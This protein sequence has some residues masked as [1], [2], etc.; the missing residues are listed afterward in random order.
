MTSLSGAAQEVPV[1]EGEDAFRARMTCFIEKGNQYY[2]LSDRPGILSMIDSLDACLGAR[3]ESGCLNSADSLEYTAHRCRLLADWHYENGNYDSQSYPKAEALFKEALAIFSSG[4]FERDYDLFRR[5][6]LYRELA[7]LYYKQE[8]YEEALDYTD[9]AEN[10]YGGAY[11]NGYFF[12]GSPDWD[13]W[14]AVRMQ[15]A[16]CLARTGRFEEALHLADSVSTSVVGSDDGIRLSVLRMRGKILLLQGGEASRKEAAV[17]YRNYL[18]WRKADA[19]KT[20]AGLS[21]AGRQDYWMQMRPFV[22][23][24]YLLE[25]EDPALL[26]DIALFSKN[27]LLQMNLMSQD[28]ATDTYLNHTWSDVES[29]LPQKSAAVEFVLYEGKMAALVVRKGAVPRWIKMPSQQEIMDYR[30]DGRPV[31]SRLST[32][33]G[34]VKNPIY[35]DDGLKRLIWNADLLQALDGCRSVYFAPDGYIH[36]LAIEYMLPSK[37]RNSVC[38]RL[39][40]TRQLLRRRP[41]STDAALIIGGVDYN[42]DLAVA[43]DGVGNDA[44]AYYFMHDLRLRFDYLKS[45]LDEAHAVMAVRANSADLIYTGANATEQVFRTTAGRFPMLCISTHGYFQASGSPVG[46]D[47]KT[48][49]SD[50]TLSESVLVLSGANRAIRS[51]SF[52]PSAPDGILS[53]AE[54][55]GLDLGHVDIAVIAACQ[56]GLGYVTSE[57]VYGI[58]RGFKN[59]GAGCLVV[60]LWNVSDE[61]TSMLMSGFQKN[62]SHGMPAHAAFEKARQSLSRKKDFSEPRY[63]NAFI[64]IDAIS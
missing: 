27:L 26:Y 18:G 54:I 7:Q 22:A 44:S 5:P 51:D 42:A 16:M 49:L 52:D 13:Q 3:R 30:I 48:C 15:K 57:G 8:R 43:D 45:S 34:N 29:A 11:L 10:A 33:D 12:E 19:L 20:M 61:A 37:L 1:P 46:T 38:Y 31:S 50:D 25:D 53:A 60:S 62:L 39:T 36:Q 47:V 64:M 14:Q 2:Y 35:E 9:K 21:P 17:L 6:V 4:L 55:S 23:D 58:Q 63:R 56:T 59:A 41:V 40:S 32:T 28:S 24:A